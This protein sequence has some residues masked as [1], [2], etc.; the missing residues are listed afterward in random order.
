M[1]ESDFKKVVRSLKLCHR[2]RI[3]FLTTLYLAIIG[4]V[5]SGILIYQY[6][7]KQVEKFYQLIFECVTSLKSSLK[8]FLIDYFDFLG[9]LGATAV[10]KMSVQKCQ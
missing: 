8:T 9:P 7:S 4:F 6:K 2:D 10:L 3:I 1:G 5:V